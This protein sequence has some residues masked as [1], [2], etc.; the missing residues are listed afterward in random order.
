MA[1]AAVPDVGTLLAP[2][3]LGAL[4]GRR[5]QAVRTR[6]F[7][8][9]DSA[10][11][12][13]F[14]AVETEG[15]AG[16]A[17]GRYLVKRVSAARD[18]LMRATAD[19]GREPLLW[20][21]GTLDRLGDRARHAV[22]AVARDEPPRPSPHPA[23]GLG[24]TPRNADGQP[25]AWALLLRDASAGL[26]P[27]RF[28]P[29]AP[30]THAAALGGIAALH[31]AY[32]EDAA[33]LALPFLCAP[34]R[35]FTALAPATGRRERDATPV[36]ARI[37]RGW[38]LFDGLVA[39]DVVEMVRALHAD[40]AP[41]CQALAAHRR[42]LLH[43]DLRRANLALERDERTGEPALVLLDWQLA[44]VGPPAADLAW[45]LAD[46]LRLPQTKE[47]TLAAYRHELERRLGTAYDDVEWE[48][49]LALGLLGG[50]LRFGW[51][52]AIFAGEHAD[53]GLRAHYRGELGWW[54]E[55]AREGARRL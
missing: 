52:L 20:L 41:L 15:A 5:V 16:E 49:T 9:A 46:A 40:P 25:A 54:G 24:P 37:V 10:S 53:A 36:A 33:T 51:L 22:V 44:T 21:A 35:Y 4:E 47:E 43:G 23:T 28:E 45:Y 39:P 2:E 32:F 50:L 27:P 17:A 12:N 18:W 38:E 34:E 29:L 7:A 19:P 48:A 14:L 42:T 31:A 6:P 30:E 11:G 8:T 26:L 13:L 55:R 1:H 3:T